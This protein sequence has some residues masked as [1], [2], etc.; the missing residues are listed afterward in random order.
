MY[1]KAK[2]WLLAI[3]E[4]YKLEWWVGGLILAGAY[5]H[6]FG[7]KNLQS[8]ISEFQA[9]LLRNYSV[10]GYVLDLLIAGFLLS[11]LMAA[12]AIIVSR[13]QKKTNMTLKEQA[14]TDPLTGLPNAKK[15]EEEFNLRSKD[16][17]KAFWICYVDVV[18][19]GAINSRFNH[20]VADN[21]LVYFSK[22]VKGEL[23][24]SQDKMFRIYG[25]EFVL[26]LTGTDDVGARACV[27][28]IVR[29]LSDQPSIAGTDRQT[30]EELKEYIQGRFGITDFDFSA[31]D[32]TLPRCIER[33]DTAVN[34]L[35]AVD[36]KFEKKEAVRMLK[37][38]EVDEDPDL[39][40]PRRRFGGG[41]RPSGAAVANAAH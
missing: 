9:Q 16:S 15:L 36:P 30:K 6:F 33:A 27:N 28:R 25:D 23:R 13:G 22:I 21:L 41:R 3:Q 39:L 10:P 37:R 26:L 5:D 31:G 32:E 4:K 34:L 35:K 18:G 14:E 38:A 20:Q 1:G 29:T 7:G 2:A 24:S 17:S 11:M 40:R 12:G 19:F 8:W